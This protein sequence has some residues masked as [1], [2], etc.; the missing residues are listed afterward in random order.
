MAVSQILWPNR[1]YI[2]W[3]DG[4]NISWAIAYEFVLSSTQPAADGTNVTQPTWPA[5]G[6]EGIN[7]LSWTP[8]GNPS[9]YVN[10]ETI[11]FDGVDSSYDTYWTLPYFAI[12]YN[13]FYMGG[14]SINPPITLGEYQILTFTPGTVLFTLNQTHVYPD[15]RN[16][17]FPEVTTPAQIFTFEPAAL[18]EPIKYGMNMRS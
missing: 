1:D 5:Y 18:S 17:A 9:Q 14:G 7:L 13:G 12:Y 4:S 10:N 8:T 2:L 3:A 16:N 6:G 15:M 11:T